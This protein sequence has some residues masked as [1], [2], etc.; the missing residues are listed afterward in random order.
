M[1][2]QRFRNKS[3]FVFFLFA[4]TCIGSYALSTRSTTSTTT[5]SHNTRTTR[6]I[7]V[8][9]SQHSHQTKKNHHNYIVPIHM[10]LPKEEFTIEDTFQSNITTMNISTLQTLKNSSQMAN[11]LKKTIPCLTSKS[12]KGSS[13][14]ISVLG[15]SEKYTGAPF[16]ASMSALRTGADLATVYC[17]LEAS[18]PIKT[19]SPE[20]MVESVYEANV[21]NQYASQE[22]KTVQNHVHVQ[23]MIEKVLSSI[24]RTHA[25]IIG[26]GLGRDA[27]VMMATAEIIKEAKRKGISM[28]LD[29]D[30]LFLIS[31]QEYRDVIAELVSPSPSGS[32]VVLT[33]NVVEY[34]RLVENIAGGSMDSLKQALP[35]IVMI[36]KGAHDIIEYFPRRNEQGKMMICKEEGGLK[37]SGGIGDILAGCIGTF[38]AW[39][40]ILS[41]NDEETDIV[42]SCFLAT[43]I[44]KRAT[45]L[46]FEKRKRAM[47]AP[48]VLEEIGFAVDDI[49]G[50]TIE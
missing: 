32:V 15:G 50:S 9:D 21:M 29:A 14:R 43:A 38:V 18:L 35:G 40:Q 10:T 25:L 28:V 39:N 30:A 19:Y 48:D 49:A 44:T 2:E 17:A 36:Q 27:N 6:R 46:A 13:G 47:T 3:F 12:H 24:D 1:T 45:A 4:V 34:N 33:P 5:T 37:R 16:Y 20:L 22:G 23:E 41:N 26:P 8:I 7:T 31:L 42:M 11:V